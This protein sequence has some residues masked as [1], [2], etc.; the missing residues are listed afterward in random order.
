ME[1]GKTYVSH[2]MQQARNPQGWGRGDIRGR[3]NIA[4]LKDFPDN[5]LPA[6]PTLF[7]RALQLKFP[8]ENN[9][10]IMTWG[11]SDVEKN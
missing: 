7:Q 3:D 1:L 10:S 11:I 9:D 6:N 4:Q 5:T 2:Q 8:T